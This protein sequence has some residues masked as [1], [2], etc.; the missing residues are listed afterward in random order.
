MPP[1]TINCSAAPD[2]E[3]LNREGCSDVENTCG[4]CFAGNFLGED[5]HAN[6]F[7]YNNTISEEGVEHCFEDS[8]CGAFREC[9][10]YT[11]NRI[12]RTCTSV[13]LVNGECAYRNATTGLV[14]DDCFVDDPTCFTF[15][16]CGTGFNGPDCDIPGIVL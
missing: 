2:C 10:D 5:G 6:T 12:S 4:H 9:V 13:C 7:C 3:S 15:C 8:S 11:C 14:I 16:A 1:V